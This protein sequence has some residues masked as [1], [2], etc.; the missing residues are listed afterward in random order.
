LAEILYKEVFF[1]I[2]GDG[3]AKNILIEKIEK[4][5]LENIKIISPVDRECLVE[6]YYKADILFLHLNDSNA[7]KYVIPSKVFEYG[8]FSK[9]ILAGVSGYTE[10]FIKNNVPN[11][12]IFSPCNVKEA[13]VQLKKIIENDIRISSNKSFIEKFSRVVIM[14]RMVKS[15]KEKYYANVYG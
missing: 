1:T 2:I 6:Y 4:K 12:F 13:Q 14:N 9:P 15:I 10:H 7:F 11:S 5:Y 8:A 3:N